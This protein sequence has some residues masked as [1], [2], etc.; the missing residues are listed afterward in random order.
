MS[1]V[2]AWC[3]VH[4]KS[5]AGKK[6]TSKVA[7]CEMD[8]T[9]PETQIRSTHKNTATGRN[10]CV[11]KPG[12]SCKFPLILNVQSS[13]F[14]R[15]LNPAKSMGVAWLEIRR[16]KSIPN[17]PLPRVGSSVVLD[18][19]PS[20]NPTTGNPHATFIFNFELHEESPEGNVSQPSFQSITSSQGPLALNRPTRGNS[21]HGQGG[22]SPV[23]PNLQG[24]DGPTSIPIV[25]DNARGEFSSSGSSDP[26][27]DSRDRRGSGL[28]TPEDM[29]GDEVILNTPRKRNS[30][31]VSQPNAQ[32]VGQ[33][34]ANKRPRLNATS[35]PSNLLLSGDDSLSESD[36]S[37][38]S[39]SY[40]LKSARVDVSLFRAYPK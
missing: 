4:T 37:N 18:W 21:I 11:E 34:G 26:S 25:F 16:V 2:T 32:V 6:I 30:T 24:P 7:A 36:D 28:D 5:A 22:K 14:T 39:E 20:D 19:L 33:D 38:D 12:G 23:S 9:K 1:P 27:S 40:T 10:L 8:A 31:A 35:G 15:V 17:Q 3:E 29:G 13:R